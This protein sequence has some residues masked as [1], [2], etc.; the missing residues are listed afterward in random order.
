MFI[1]RCRSLWFM[2]QT[3][4]ASISL[5]Q[6]FVWLPQKCTTLNF[7]ISNFRVRSCIFHFKLH[8]TSF[9][10]STT[11]H[12]KFTRTKDEFP[13]TSFALLLHNTVAW[14]PYQIPHSM[15]TAVNS[16][17]EEMWMQSTI[18]KV[19]G[20][21]L[22]L[23]PLIPIPKKGGDVCLVLD[24][25]IPNQPCTQRRVQIPTADRILQKME[26]QQFPL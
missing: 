17:V 14:W 15:K 12:G 2:S 22:W 7:A 20:W 4:A 3:F 21:M 18:E 24:M 16:K 10:N 26:A 5:S 23:S 19:E 13:R 25:R 8:E 11:F 9:E 1:D 6:I